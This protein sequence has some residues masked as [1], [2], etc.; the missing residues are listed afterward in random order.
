[1]LPPDNGK[2]WRRAHND[3]GCRVLR[4]LGAC[5][6]EAAVDAEIDRGPRFRF[7]C[8]ARDSTIPKGCRVDQDALDRGPTQ[9]TRA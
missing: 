8:R 1:V 4:L 2:S 5:I 6:G 7:L 9:V 3:R